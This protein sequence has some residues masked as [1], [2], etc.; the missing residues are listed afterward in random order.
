MVSKKKLT[1]VYPLKWY[2]YGSSSMRRK[3]NGKMQLVWLI[4]LLYTCLKSIF[5]YSNFLLLFITMSCYVKFR[6]FYFLERPRNFC[7]GQMIGSLTFIYLLLNLWSCTWLV[8]Y[9]FGKKREY[10]NFHAGFLA[11]CLKTTF[12]KQDRLPRYWIKVCNDFY[13]ICGIFSNLLNVLENCTFGLFKH[14]LNR[15]R[16]QSFFVYLNCLELE[17]YQ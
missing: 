2:R 7:L 13:I 16:L 10:L 4:L 6:Y 5:I 12:L 11:M 15:V 1:N 9:V 17:K 3:N 8:I 14:V